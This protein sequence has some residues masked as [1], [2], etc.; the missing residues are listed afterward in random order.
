MPTYTQTNRPLG[1]TTPLGADVLLL[2]GFTGRE[3][4]SQLFSFQLDLVADHA[5]DVAFDKLLGQPVTLRVNLSGDKKRFF[6]GICSRFSQGESDTYFTHYRME[7][8]PA[9]WLWTKRAQSRIFQQKSVP[10][11]L[12]EVLKGLDVAY[13][14]QGTFEPR[15]YCVQSRE[16]D[17]A[18]ASRRREEEGIYYFFKH[19]DGGHKLVLANTPA[20]HADLPLGSALVYKTIEQGE[21]PEGSF[22]YGWAKTQELTSGK[23]VLWD[24]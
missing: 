22:V 24:H 4:V 19:S 10:D 14:I 17:V 18:L 7:V 16:S 23:V 9:L 20:S 6:N 12:K 1:V 5:A 13:E 2:T 11:I 21:A 15:D 3:G 8:V